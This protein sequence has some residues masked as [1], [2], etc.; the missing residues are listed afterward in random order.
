VCVSLSV[1]MYVCVCL[2][3]S[4]ESIAQAYSKLYRTRDFRCVCVSLSLSPSRAPISCVHVC[5]S[6]WFPVSLSLFPYPFLW[7][8][9]HCV[10]LFFHLFCM[11]VRLSLSLSLC[12][13]CTLLVGPDRVPAKVHKTVLIA[14]SPVFE[15]YVCVCVCLC[16]LPLS[17]EIY[18]L[19]LIFSSNFFFRLLGEE[20]QGASELAIPGVCVCGSLSPC[21]SVCVCDCYF[22]SSLFLLFFRLFSPVCMCVCLSFSCIDAHP[23]ALNA[24]LQFIYEGTLNIK[25]CLCLCVCVRLCLL[26]VLTKSLLLLSCRSLTRCLSSSLSPPLSLPLFLSVCLSLSFSAQV[27]HATAGAG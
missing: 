14:R 10:S 24:V 20:N 6:F 5:V 13:D 2:S 8:V 25:V 4:Q 17:V 27:L 18:I 19:V 7:Y 16:V 9:P 21:V 26:P 22:Q 3:L 11:R 15:K 12:S 23:K 1:C